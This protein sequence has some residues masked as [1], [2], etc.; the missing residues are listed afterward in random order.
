MATASRAKRQRRMPPVEDTSGT[1]VLHREVVAMRPVDVM[2]VALTVAHAWRDGSDTE[3]LVTADLVSLFDSFRGGMLKSEYRRGDAT[4]QRVLAAATQAADDSAGATRLLTG[5]LARMPIHRCHNIVTYQLASAQ[6]TC[7]ARHLCLL[8]G[9]LLDTDTLPQRPRAG[10]ATDRR[11]ALRALLGSLVRWSGPLLASEL[12]GQ[13]MGYHAGPVAERFSA[14]VAGAAMVHVRRAP[15]ES[16]LEVHKAI[17][18]ALYRGIMFD[19]LGHGGL[20]TGM[21]WGGVLSGLS[22]TNTFGIAVDTENPH[23]VAYAR[24][25]CDVHQERTVGGPVGDDRA[26]ALTGSRG[27]LLRS[28][29]SGPAVA[30]GP[31]HDAGGRQRPRWT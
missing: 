24:P 19:L 23:A 31:G 14:A 30:R 29:L 15:S 28:V 17:C 9:L 2:G 5:E 13:V 1:A 7:S 4:M 20:D 21:E 18:H 27:H 16:I 26:A 8:V 22:V 10:C 11:E 6:N 12:F 25:S 3:R